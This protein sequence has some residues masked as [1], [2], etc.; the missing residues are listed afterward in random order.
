MAGD[1]WPQHPGEWEETEIYVGHDGREILRGDQG[2]LTYANLLA[3]C[4]RLQRQNNDKE[5]KLELANRQIAALTFQNAALEDKLHSETIAQEEQEK[6]RNRFISTFKRDK[7]HCDTTEDREAIRE[8]NECAHGGDAIRDAQLYTGRGKRQDEE[9]FVKLYGVSPETVN[10]IR[11]TKM[12]Y[13]LNMHATVR[14][15]KY[16]RATETYYRCFHKLA[17]LLRATGDNSSR[18]QSNLTDLAITNSYWE[19]IHASATEV[20]DTR[21]KGD[22]QVNTGASNIFPSMETRSM[23]SDTS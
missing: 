1:N 7:L 14:A 19:F 20:T 13:A 8:G 17:N 23:S 2:G 16:K 3:T 18:H 12:I 5:K 4:Q 22:V 6:L 10:R 15:S 11:S 21:E 9:A